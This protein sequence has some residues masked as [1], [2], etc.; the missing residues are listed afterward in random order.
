MD[1]QKRLIKKYPNR[2]SYDTDASAYITIDNVRQLVLDGEDVQIIDV[3][4]REDITRGVLLQI[5]LDEHAAGVPLFNRELLNHLI[6]LSGQGAQQALG[7]FLE[8]NIRLFLQLQQQTLKLHGANPILD[9][10]LWRDFLDLQGPV[11]QDM[12]SSYLA[13]SA[14]LYLG[15]QQ[16]LR[17]QTGRLFAESTTD[18]RETD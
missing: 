1:S 10:K 15:M 11:M 2:R 6:R 7:I 3:K 18:D 8:E 16:R 9:H 4:S 12:M 13:Q 5:V 17:E 14:Q